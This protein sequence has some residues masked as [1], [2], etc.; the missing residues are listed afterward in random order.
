MELAVHAPSPSFSHHIPLL[1]C[2]A[3]LASY[4]SSASSDSD[5][6]VTLHFTIPEDRVSP[7]DFTA[8]AAAVLLPF[9]L[10][11]EGPASSEHSA[12]LSWHCAL[13]SQEAELSQLTL[14]SVTLHFL[15]SLC[16]RDLVVATDPSVL[17]PMSHDLRSLLP[18]LPSLNQKWMTPSTLQ[19]HPGSA[20]HCARFCNRIPR[21]AHTLWE[22]LA[23]QDC[24]TRFSRESAL[25]GCSK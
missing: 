23:Q 1:N 14:R 18:Q 5:S 19:N 22:R 7:A 3:T 12:S 2:N 8:A 20:Q 21:W 15:S 13:Q 4:K 16:V 6:E 11:Q 9:A 10:N 25:T 24:R 17:D